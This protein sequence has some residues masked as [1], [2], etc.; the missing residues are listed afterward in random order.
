VNAYR[1][2]YVQV[3]VFE[4]EEEIVTEKIEHTM[5][6][7]ADLLKREGRKRWPGIRF[8]LHQTATTFPIKAVASDGRVLVVR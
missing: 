3:T 1:Y 5:E 4:G 2:K 7:I 6:D 8:R